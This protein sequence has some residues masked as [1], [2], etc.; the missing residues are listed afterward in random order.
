MDIQSS[1]PPSLVFKWKWRHDSISRD[2]WST[3]PW[4][5]ATSAALPNSPTNGTPRNSD[6]HRH[7]TLVPRW[8]VSSRWL[9]ARLMPSGSQS[10]E[11]RTLCWGSPQIDVSRANLAPSIVHIEKTWSSTWLGF[12]EVVD[13][14]LCELKSK[15][16]NLG[17]IDILLCAVDPLGQGASES[18]QF[19]P[20]S[21]KSLS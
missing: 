18:S 17:D 15:L 4:A 1:L 14:R 21:G 10:P 6:G 8:L 20:V 19:V 16:P 11:L 7:E 5:G 2:A 3:R 9:V 12:K 13:W